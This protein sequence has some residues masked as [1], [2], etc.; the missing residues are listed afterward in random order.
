[1]NNVNR[2]SVIDLLI[3]SLKNM[4]L[5]YII[6]TLPFY[7][8]LN[9]INMYNYAMIIFI[10]IVSYYICYVFSKS[11]IE[12]L[13][14]TGGNLIGTF[15]MS[16]SI[17]LLLL[18]NYNIIFIIF[19]VLLSFSS[20]IIDNSIK[21]KNIN[22]SI[23]NLFMVLY[24][25]VLVTG[26]IFFGN[27]FKLIYSS[28][29]LILITV[30]IISIIYEKNSIGYKKVTLNKR[31]KMYIISLSDIHRIKNLNALIIIILINS[32]LYMSVIMVFTFVPVLAV[33]YIYNYTIFIER[34]FTIMLISFFTY[35]IGILIKNNYYYLLS[36]FG[37]NIFIL[38]FIFIIT[39]RGNINFLYYG[40]LLVPVIAFLMPG[41]YRYRNRKFMFSEAYYINKFVNF[42]SMFFIIISPLTGLY[43]YNKPRIV[44]TLSMLPMLIVIILALKFINYPDVIHIISK[45]KNIKIN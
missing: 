6:I 38:L 5:I 25:A 29:I 16:V 34:F 39:I 21:I 9:L 42:F 19:P 2:G 40:L 35:F 26:I 1:M 17:L 44:L 43:F 12:T 22:K 7:F 14:N 4:F 3:Y 13:N 8:T 37:M 41:Y 20:S 45:D 32:L 28:F 23:S 31:L 18:K 36:F 30:G 33:K 11:I 27:V 24:F 10:F 15:S